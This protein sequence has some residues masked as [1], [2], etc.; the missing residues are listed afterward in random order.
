MSFELMP[1][2]LG[3]PIEEKVLEHNCLTER[4]RR[5]HK[6]RIGWKCYQKFRSYL[7]RSDPK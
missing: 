7:K 2:I 5:A 4:A 6:K 3:Y 1:M